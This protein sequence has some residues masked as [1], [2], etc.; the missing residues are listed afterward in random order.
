MDD[1]MM[2]AAPTPEHKASRSMNAMEIE[3]LRY[4]VNENSTR[5]DADCDSPMSHLSYSKA[6]KQEESPM[7]PLTRLIETYTW[8]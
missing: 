8:K 3:A 4:M 5:R 1:S 2:A 7:R 6:Y